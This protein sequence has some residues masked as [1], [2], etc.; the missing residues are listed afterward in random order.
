MFMSQ[1]RRTHVADSRGSCVTQYT[2]LM[3]KHRVRVSCVLLRSST[4][5]IFPFTLS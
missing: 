4:L 1:S 3:Q 5:S 2:M